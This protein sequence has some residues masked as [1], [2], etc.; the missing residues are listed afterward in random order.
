M[1]GGAAARANKQRKG[2]R[3]GRSNGKGKGKGRRE[4]RHD[5]DTESG[6]QKGGGYRGVEIIYDH[7]TG[8]AN[9]HN[10]KQSA[11]L[12]EKARREAARKWKKVA[13]GYDEAPRLRMG[14]L[15]LKKLK[16][17]LESYRDAQRIMKEEV[18]DIDAEDD[19]ENE[20]GLDSE[21]EEL[22]RD[23]NGPGFYGMPESDD[24]DDSENES[25]EEESYDS[26]D[27]EGF[28]SD[29]N[30][31][32]RESYG[33]TEESTSDGSYSQDSGVRTFST[34]PSVYVPEASSK[35]R[36]YME[37]IESHGALGGTG[38]GQ[39]ASSQYYP[40]TPSRTHH[41]LDDSDTQESSEGVS[42]LHFNLLVAV[43]LKSCSSCRMS[44]RIRLYH[45]IGL[46]LST[47]H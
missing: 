40:S 5:K 45:A 24:D 37:G 29:D 7:R 30:I 28:E 22:I 13:K 39:G 34:S 43:S 47:T 3:N 23:I 11:V 20:D 17:V 26:E 42:S 15:M 19:G 38:S 1:A 44:Y 8:E 18:G 32:Q 10:R 46:R 33:E 9:E 6:G 31:I 14:S 27:E 35:G 25:D 36:N 41:R 12:R 16:A 4:S 2:G 21:A